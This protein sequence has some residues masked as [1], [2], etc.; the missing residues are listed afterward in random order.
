M[1]TLYTLHTLKLVVKGFELIPE[2]LPP[3]IVQCERA[4]HTFFTLP[5]QAI[6]IYGFILLSAESAV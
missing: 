2:E 4:A 3:L 6:G 1:F 5:N